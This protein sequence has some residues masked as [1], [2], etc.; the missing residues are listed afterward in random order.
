MDWRWPPAGTAGEFTL[1]GEALSPT[2]QR[3]TL[4]RALLAALP[5]AVLVA[6]LTAWLYPRR[7]VR[8]VRL[9]E[10]GSR[11]LAA[12]QYD[13]RLPETGRDELADL[14]HHFNTL[15]SAPHG[16]SRAASS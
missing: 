6:A 12:G 4:T 15:A 7:V 2:P 10:G 9:L 3:P 16:W 13:Q 5:L 14:A 8:S 1:R 11:A